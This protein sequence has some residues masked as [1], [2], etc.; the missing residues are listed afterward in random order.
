MSVKFYITFSELP[1]VQIYR[2]KQALPLLLFGVFF[3]YVN[4]SAAQSGKKEASNWIYPGSNGKLIYKT[5]PAGDRIMD[6]SHAGYGGG[7]VSLPDVPVKRKVKPSG[8]EDDTSIIQ[9]AIDEVSQLP[10]KKGFRG[11]VLLEAGVF[12]CNKPLVLSVS[13]VVL[14]GTLGE[15][16]S[17][18]TTIRMVGDKHTA[19]IIGKRTQESSGENEGSDDKQKTGSLQT[20][21]T[22]PY[23]PSGANSFTVA[24]A[25]GF[26]TGDIIAIRRPVTKAWIKFMQMDNLVRDGKPQT[27]IGGARTEVTERKI[28]AISG[29]KLTLDVPLSDSY[30]AKYL[31]PPGT[32]VTKIIPDPIVTQV[33]VE[34]LHIQ[35]APLEIAYGQA[36][37]SAIL[38]NGDDCWANDIYCE[39]TMNSTVL[40]GNRITMQR[41]VITHTFP[42]LGASKPTDFSI[43]GSQILIDRCKVTGD[44]EYFVWTSS[45]ITGPNVILNSTFNGHGSRIQPHQR[46]ATG[47]LID[48]CKVP[49][50]GIDYMNRGVAGSGHGWTMAWAVVWNSLA[51]TFII[52]NPPGTLNWAIGCSGTRMQTARLFDSQ[53][54]EPEGVF[55][56]HG[57]QV[58]PQSLYLAQLSERL[59]KQAIKNIGYSSNTENEF[60]D[61]SLHEL[62]PL[63][64]DTD[65]QLGIDLALFRPV[66][67]SSVRGSTREFG[68][69]KALDK[70]DKTWWA[71][72]TTTGTFEVDLEGPVEINAVLVSEPPGLENIQQ[73]KIESQ[74]DSDWKLLAEGTTIGER[75]VHE[76]NTVVAWKV[77]L[78][79]LRASASPAIRKFGLYKTS[80]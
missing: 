71:P 66:N 61:R 74:T 19:I 1:F 69:E 10:M 42:N 57:K 21:I 14:R 65:S 8:G 75:K 18:G 33:G 29:N 63:P 50:G 76:F 26:K 2:M 73:Y 54:I 27:W 40:R 58:S 9:K 56:S 13:G 34:H 49:D 68:G 32:L 77:R 52:Q 37:Y 7:G 6:F 41:V 55:D 51:K 4:Q 39:E 44:N 25:K 30:D 3:V 5:T 17:K 20:F 28:T 80:K 22:D 38:I 23:V 70:N 35:C 78:T 43:E 67:T 11:A 45:L 72:N 36:P 79:I 62:S 16:T 46:W 31:N 48:N 47:V 53:P 64:E 59:G 60:E 15:N 24:D 12:N